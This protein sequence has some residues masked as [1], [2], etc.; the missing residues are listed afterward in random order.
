MKK[1]NCI[2]WAKSNNIDRFTIDYVDFLV[3]GKLVHSIPGN[4][5]LF[6]KFEKVHKYI[7][8]EMCKHGYWGNR[9][10]IFEPDEQ[11]DDRLICIKSWEQNK[12]GDIV[13]LDLVEGNPI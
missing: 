11:H 2:I 12:Q 1:C 5:V 6:D 4:E 3:N 13:K 7:M 9:F 10:A 8:N